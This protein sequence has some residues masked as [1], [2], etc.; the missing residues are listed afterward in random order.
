MSYTNAMKKLDFMKGKQ[1]MYKTVNI[2]IQNYVVCADFVQIHLSNKK[3]IEIPA[4][5]LASTLKEFLSL[6][7]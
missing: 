2:T 3:Y 6:V 5:K 1:W 7:K 4:K